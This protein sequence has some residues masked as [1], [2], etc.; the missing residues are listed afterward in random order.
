[1]KLGSHLSWGSLVTGALLGA[2][3]TVGVI[4]GPAIVRNVQDRQKAAAVKAENTRSTEVQV[5]AAEALGYKVEAMKV[6]RLSDGTYEAR[7][8]RN[9]RLIYAYNNDGQLRLVSR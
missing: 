7:G 3:T 1:M 4:E 6:T 5:R 9:E 2:T 8:P